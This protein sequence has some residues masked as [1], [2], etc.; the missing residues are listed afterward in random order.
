[1]ILTQATIDILTTE[2][3]VIFQVSDLR[4]YCLTL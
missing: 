1:M 4:I 3:T 2:V